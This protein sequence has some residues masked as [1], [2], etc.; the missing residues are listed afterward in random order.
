VHIYPAI[1]PETGERLEFDGLAWS[2][3]VR[4]LIRYLIETG[5]LSELEGLPDE[6]L[7]FRSDEVLAL[8]KAGDPSWADQVEPA[9]AEVIR[10]DGLFGEGR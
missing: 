5:R 1:D 7:R 10:R 6:Q 9:V 3:A 4:H 2:D 8:I